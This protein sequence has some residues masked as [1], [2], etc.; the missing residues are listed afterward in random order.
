MI[1]VCNICREPESQGFSVCNLHA[2]CYK[3]DYCP[4]CGEQ[5]D[6]LVFEDEYQFY[7]WEEE[8]EDD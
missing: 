7:Q 1:Y 6:F 4:F 8:Q 2:E 3:I 5:N